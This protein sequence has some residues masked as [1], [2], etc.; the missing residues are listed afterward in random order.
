MRDSRLLIDIGVEILN[1]VEP[2]AKSM[3]SARLKEK[4]AEKICFEGAIDVQQA[5]RGS[6]IDVQKEVRQRI[7]DLNRGG[8]CI[9]GPSH[10]IEDEIPL[11]NILAL[12]EEAHKGNQSPSSYHAQNQSLLCRNH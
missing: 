3:D 12:L 8:G 4:Y 7:E 11:E 5:M 6:V 9:L 2:L 10:N 1:S